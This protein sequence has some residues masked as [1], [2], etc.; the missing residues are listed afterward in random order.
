MNSEKFQL[1]Q[2]SEIHIFNL[3]VNWEKLGSTAYVQESKVPILNLM[4]NWE[5]LNPN[6]SF[7][8]ENKME[9]LHKA[10]HNSTFT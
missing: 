10:D 1:E 3:F 4:M 2:H 6:L 7:T 8:T 5:K 9:N